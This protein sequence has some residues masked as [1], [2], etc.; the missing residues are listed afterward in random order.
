MV[1]RT[2]GW[3]QNP[4]D[5]NKL[6]LVVQI[7]D[8]NSK[9]Y[10][11]LKN[12]LV[13]NYIPL[14]DIRNNLLEKLN[15]NISEFSYSELVGTSKNKDGNPAK[16]RKE[17]IADALI[18]VTVLPQSSE[19]TGKM[20]TDNWTADGYL[21]WALSLNFIQHDRETD[22]CKITD[23]GKKFSSSKPNSSDELEI[24]K[25]SLLSYP[26]ATQVLNIL[27]H[28][29]EPVTKFFIGNQLGFRGEKGFTSYDESLMKTWFAE[30]TLTEQKKIK[31]D[32]EGTSDK[33]ARMICNWLAKVGY[34]SKK[35]DSVQTRIGK[36]PG[37]PVY[38]ITARGS[39]DL[40]R[41]NG[42][43]KNSKIKKFLTWEFLAVDCQNRNYVRSRRAYILQLLKTTKSFN[44]LLHNLKELGFND[45]VEIINNDLEGLNNFGIRIE[46]NANNINLKDDFCDFTI[47]NLNITEELKNKASDKLKVKLLKCTSLPMKYIELLDIAYDS[48]R[49]RDFEIITTDLFKNVFG[50][51]AMHLGGGRKPDGIIHTSSF[52]IILDTKAYRNGYSKSIS[53]EDEMVRYIED[54]TLRDVV[55]NSTEWWKNFN[56]EIPKG[57]FYFLWISSKFIGRFEEQLT[58][59]YNRTKTYGGALNVEQLLVGAHKIQK[60]DIKVSEIP[61]YFK[62]KEISW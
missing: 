57:S 46:K 30:S 45:D 49:S 26:P 17:A 47:P 59:T 25:E 15:D 43:A 54:N 37:V 56:P 1:S 39:Y 55:R 35:Q 44:V 18:Q 33:Y 51:E 5:F 7:F 6:K 10:E 61:S 14:I 29:K 8:K 60:G 48:K 38:S 9:H 40:R 16:S 13:P 4:S 41:A 53:Q 36:K 62:N 23:L 52:G 22:M 34:V 27:D 50:I 3:V 12:N 32:I 21:R 19:T 28:T 31:S 58:S 42:S 24:I 2:Y 20:W 11:N